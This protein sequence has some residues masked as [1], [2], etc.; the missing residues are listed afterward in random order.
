LLLAATEKEI[1]QS[2]CRTHFGRQRHGGN[3]GTSNKHAAQLAQK[4]QF[5]TQSLLH[6]TQRPLCTTNGALSSH[7]LNRGCETRCKLGEE[8]E[9]NR[10]VGGKHHIS[11]VMHAGLDARRVCGHPRKD[12]GVQQHPQGWLVASTSSRRRR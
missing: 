6:R 11:A 2:F 8:G 1:K 3:D 9:G 10:R 5:G 12:G 7:W 4:G